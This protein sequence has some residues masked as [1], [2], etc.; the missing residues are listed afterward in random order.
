[1]SSWIAQSLCQ[2]AAAAADSII[3]AALAFYQL[4][5]V[6]PA[7]LAHILWGCG[8]VKQQLVEGCSTRLCAAAD[9]LRGLVG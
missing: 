3:D 1:M 4:L 6:Y 8:A 7:Q 9:S 5:M 2:H